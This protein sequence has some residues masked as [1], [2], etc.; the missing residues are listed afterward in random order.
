M[1]YHYSI[2]I[3]LS[4]YILEL[5]ENHPDTQIVKNN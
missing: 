2:F 4:Y 5:R 3:Q 1:N